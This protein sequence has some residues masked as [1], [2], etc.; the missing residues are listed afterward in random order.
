L[1]YSV[2]AV[3]TVAT[4]ATVAVAASSKIQTNISYIKLSRILLSIFF[5]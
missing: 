5:I 2:A 1:N 3:A 4:V